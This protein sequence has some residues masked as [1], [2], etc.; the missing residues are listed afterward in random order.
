M[1]MSAM[2]GMPADDASTSEAG[3]CD[4]ACVGVHVRTCDAVCEHE[5]GHAV[6]AVQALSR[7]HLH[8][9]HKRREAGDGHE[10]EKGAHEEQQRGAPEEARAD[11]R[12]DVMLAEQEQ[13]QSS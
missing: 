7:E 1:A 12:L 4:V 8:V 2:K 6:V 10:G 13:A 5:R 9:L 11:T 3:V